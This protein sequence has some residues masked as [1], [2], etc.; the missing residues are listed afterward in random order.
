MN[1][2][3]MVSFQSGFQLCHVFEV[4]HVYIG[5]NC[6]CVLEH[7]DCLDPVPDFL[8]DIPG[9]LTEIDVPF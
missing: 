5:V 1:F 6:I 3:G 9:T 4:R 2:S 8:Q 7:V